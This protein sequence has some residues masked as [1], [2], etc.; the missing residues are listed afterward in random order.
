MRNPTLMAS[1]NPND[2]QIP[3]H[4][5]LGL[6]HTDLG[7]RGRHRYQ[8]LRPQTVVLEASSHAL[9]PSRGP[10]PTRIHPPF[11]AQLKTLSQEGLSD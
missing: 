3:S 11:E 9:L 10:P 2:P 7:E 5:G 8:Y 1:S 6:Q 4:R